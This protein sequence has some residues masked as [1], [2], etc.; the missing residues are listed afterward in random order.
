MG[1]PV[2]E[3]WLGGTRAGELNIKYKGKNIKKYFPA[4]FFSNEAY[5]WNYCLQNR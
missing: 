2:P 3:D 4:F 1:S 5:R